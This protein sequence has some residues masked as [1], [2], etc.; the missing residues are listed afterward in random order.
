MKQ[1]LAYIAACLRYEPPGMAWNS[2]GGLNVF[3]SMDNL[4]KGTGY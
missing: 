2:N 4:R 3:V 1:L